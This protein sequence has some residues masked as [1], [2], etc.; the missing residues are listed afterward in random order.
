MPPRANH[1]RITGESRAACSPR[2]AIV[3]RGACR[4]TVPGNCGGESARRGSDRLGPFSSEELTNI[5]DTLALEACALTV[6]TLGRDMYGGYL[7]SHPRRARR[8]TQVPVAQLT[9]AVPRRRDQTWRHQYGGLTYRSRRASMTRIRIGIYIFGA[10]G[11]RVA[12]GHDDGQLIASPSRITT[13]RKAAWWA[14]SCM[15]ATSRPRSTPPTRRL[16]WR[17]TRVSHENQ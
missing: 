1:G 10:P 15:F 6:N 7:P 3:S 12:R 11:G 8:A 17:A 9:P 16:A 4:A 14:G 13:F 2:A 5:S